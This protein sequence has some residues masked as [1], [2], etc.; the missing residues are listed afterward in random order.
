MENAA[1]AL[2][3]AAAVLIFVLALTI[4][5]NSFS[6]ARQTA[7]LILDYNDREYDYT[8]VEQNIDGE[9]N[10]V[11]KRLVSL[12][13]MIPTIYKAYRENYK[14]RFVGLNESDYLYELR[15]DDGNWEKVY[16]IDMETGGTLAGDEDKLQFIMAVLYGN[17]ME[18]PDGETF[19]GKDGIKEDYLEKGF[20]LKNKGLYDTIKEG[21]GNRLFEESIG[22]YYQEEVKKAGE[23]TPGPDDEDDTAIVPEANLTE[24]R[25]ITY[26]LQ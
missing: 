25:V 13:S 12:E 23:T 10:L 6:Q 14:I 4:A 9:G 19:D 22:V 18:L 11:T 5:I 21:Y 8:Y 20:R 15:D 2:Q 24:K 1:D 17:K 16:K 26:T 7:Q 3:M